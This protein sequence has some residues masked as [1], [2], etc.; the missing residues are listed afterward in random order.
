[1]KSRI[2]LF[3]IAAFLALSAMAQHNVKIYDLLNE[4]KYAKQD[5]TKADI[6]LALAKEYYPTDVT[7][8]V[9]KAELA[10]VIATNKNDTR[11]RFDAL[12]LLVDAAQQQQNL[13]L[14][15]R[16]LAQAQSLSSSIL[17]LSQKA[18]LYGLEGNL[19]LSLEDFDK[20]QQ[21]F[22]QQLKI[23]EANPQWATSAEIAKIYFS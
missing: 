3:I 11:R 4:L 14:A 18:K 20:S 1:V 9:G 22:Q 8:A 13:A 16:Y 12:V 17:S 21:A 6:F 23:Y 2:F 7:K 10:L 5:T 19:F 15:A